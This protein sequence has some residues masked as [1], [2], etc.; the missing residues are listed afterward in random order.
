ME[1]A[2]I[3]DLDKKKFIRKVKLRDKQ[4]CVFGGRGGGRGGARS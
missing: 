2:L 1:E 3:V 4:I